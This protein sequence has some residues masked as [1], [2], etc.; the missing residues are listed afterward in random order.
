MRMRWTR[1][2]A[3]HLRLLRCEPSARVEIVPRSTNPTSL[4]RSLARTCV[5]MMRAS[6]LGHT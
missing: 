6:T 4:I 3:R 1:V 2:A 5:S